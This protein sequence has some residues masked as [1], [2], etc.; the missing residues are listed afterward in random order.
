MAYCNAN[1][2]VGNLNLGSLLFNQ[3]RSSPVRIQAHGLFPSVTPTPALRLVASARPS[4]LPVCITT[5]FLRRIAIELKDYLGEFAKANCHR[6]DGPDKPFPGREA[7]L[8][9]APRI[10]YWIKTSDLAKAHRALI[11]ETL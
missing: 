10:G 11:P 6:D 5:P 7:N 3:A 9:P 4:G 2:S 8:F 1:Y